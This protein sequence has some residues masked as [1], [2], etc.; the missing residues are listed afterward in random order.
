MRDERSAGVGH[1]GRLVGEHLAGIP[2]VAPVGGQQGGRGSQRSPRRRSGSGRAPPDRR[3]AAA[4]RAAGFEESIPSGS[5]RYSQ[6]T[7]AGAKL[8]APCAVM[9]ASVKQ[10]NHIAWSGTF[11]RRR[12]RMNIPG[13]ATRLSTRFAQP[14]PGT[15]LRCR[16]GK[17]PS[18]ATTVILARSSCGSALVGRS[19]PLLRRIWPAWQRRGRSGTLLPTKDYSNDLC[20]R[21]SLRL[22]EP[23]G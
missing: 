2:Q 14:L 18:H 12:I 20:S 5:T 3:V 22:E 11:R 23:L 6:R 15:R 16:V 4:S 8:H 17:V 10:A 19:V 13:I 21:Q 9:A 7:R 1:L